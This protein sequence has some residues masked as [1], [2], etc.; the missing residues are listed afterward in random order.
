VL[1]VAAPSCSAVAVIVPIVVVAVSVSLLVEAPTPVGAVVP[2]PTR[3]AVVAVPVVVAAT[4]V[5]AIVTPISVVPP[6]AVV[7]MP[8]MVIAPMPVVIPPSI[9]VL[10]TAR[11]G[12]LAA[13]VLRCSIAI[14]LAAGIASSTTAIRTPVRIHRIKTRS[15]GDALYWSLKEYVS[16]VHGKKSLE[17]YYKLLRKGTPGRLWWT[18]LE[19]QLFA[20]C[21][22]VSIDVYTPRLA[23]GKI[24]V[25]G[26]F[27][28]VD[29]K[30]V[31]ILLE[32]AHFQALLL[33]FKG[34]DV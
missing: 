18:D 3:V 11:N 8:P 23:D 6:T 1:L 22:K 20:L 2:V 13:C 31:A 9:P 4:A 26:S 27:G 33:N 30:H 16:I 7:V 21:F 15:H 10:V 29:K 19:L 34:K 5:P 32:N 14:C 17:A 28:N 24:A 12:D 25:L